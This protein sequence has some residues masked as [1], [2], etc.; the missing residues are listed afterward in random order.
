MAP[1]IPLGQWFPHNAA[2][3][4]LIPIP[5]QPISQLMQLSDT[6][7]RLQELGF[8]TALG[9]VEDLQGGAFQGEGCILQVSAQLL[10][11]LG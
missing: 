8:L 4:N 3:P 7:H 9:L 2:G 6:L 11:G 1:Q 10:V 5:H